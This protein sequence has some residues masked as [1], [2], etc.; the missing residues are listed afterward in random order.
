VIF[1]ILTGSR[2]ELSV[3]VHIGGFEEFMYKH[4]TDAIEGRLGRASSAVLQ[5]SRRQN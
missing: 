4:G 1:I 2:D 5:R 3:P